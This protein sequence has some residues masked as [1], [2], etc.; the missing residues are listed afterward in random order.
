ML[1]QDVIDHSFRAVCPAAFGRL[2]VETMSLKKVSDK[3]LPAAFGRLCVETYRAALTVLYGFQPPSGGCVLKHWTYWVLLKTRL[4][5]AFGRLC[6]E[7]SLAEDAPNPDIPAA[8]GR[9]CVETRP[10]D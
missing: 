8:F 10:T 6:V 9:L 3:S 1:K 4:P 7:T 2:C 5:A